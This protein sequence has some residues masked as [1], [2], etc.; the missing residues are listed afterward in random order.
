MV[1]ASDLSESKQPRMRTSEL[2][3]SDTAIDKLELQ[4]RAIRTNA[5]HKKVRMLMADAK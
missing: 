1:T 2:K 3:V 4:K 5:N